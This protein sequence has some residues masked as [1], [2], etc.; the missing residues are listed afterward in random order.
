NA[1]ALDALTSSSFDLIVASMSLMDAEDYDGAIREAH[2]VLR[3]GGEL[4]MSITHP[5]FSTPVSHWNRSSDGRLVEFAVD[6]YF[7]R[8]A[9]ESPIT[10][11]FQ[12]P[13]LRR[14]RPL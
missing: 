12:T 1:N 13:V 5:C 7:D 11:R 6:R 14:H 3:P 10:D 8:V 2:R 9:W 4:V